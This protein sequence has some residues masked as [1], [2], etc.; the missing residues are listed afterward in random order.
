M[1]RDYIKLL[2]VKHYIKNVLIFVPLIF[3]GSLF[4]GKLLVKD[5]CGFISFSL[6]SSVVYIFNDINDI[7]KDKAHPTKRN[8]PLASGRISKQKAYSMLIL[9]LGIA[10]VIAICIG[11]K[12]GLMCLGVYLVLNIF[13]SVEL[14]NRPIID[15]VILVSGFFLRILFGSLITN[16]VISTWLF[17]TIIASSFYLA[18]GKRRNELR[19]STGKTRAVLKLYNHEFLDK[20]MY[21]C[22]ALAN[23]FYSLWA[24]DYS[25][26]KMIWSVPM[27]LVISMKYS[28]NVEGDSD[29]DPT[30]VILHDKVMIAMVIAYVM[31]IGA[32]LYL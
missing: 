17:L 11:S 27:V 2:R 14:K 10:V 32:L 19:V 13:Y 30:E 29:G 6:I 23:V 28:L 8:R 4:E 31:F 22:L 26:A 1:I 9:C 12:Q 16:I 21:M 24:A 18:L 5:I 15:I 3:N 7:E 20:N 25:N